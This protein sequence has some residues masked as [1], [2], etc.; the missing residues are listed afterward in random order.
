MLILRLLMR[1]FLFFSFVT[2]LLGLAS[3]G[4]RPNSSASSSEV[5]IIDVESALADLQDGLK[6]SY[7]G[8]RVR[9]VPLE[10]NDSC[11]V[12]AH[13]KA[14]V[15]D[16]YVLVT[17]RIGTEHFVHAF[18]RRTG[19]SVAKVGHRGE[20]P[21][22][23]TDFTPYYNAYNDLL[24]FERIP[25]QLQKYDW[26]GNYHGRAF[27]PVWPRR[28]ASYFFCDSLVIGYHEPSV[29]EPVGSRLLSVFDETGEVKDSVPRLSGFP[30]RKEEEIACIGNSRITD[31]GWLH[32]A[33]Y[34][35]GS[36]SCFLS[37]VH[38]LWK[39]GESIR[40]KDGLN[41]TIYTWEKGIGLYP[42]FV[43]HTGKEEEDSQGGSVRDSWVFGVF[44][45]SEK[46]FFQYVK[47]AFRVIHQ[48][49]AATL[50]F[51]EGKSASIEDFPYE[52]YNGMYDKQTGVTR[53]ALWGEGLED[54]LAGGPS[55]EVQ[56]TSTQEE[57]VGVL[58]AGEVVG[59]LEAH[60][61]AKDNPRLAPLLKVKEEDNPVVVIVSDK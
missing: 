46:I 31:W 60:P 26:Q 34:K 44:E 6:L 51:L 12:A 7:F 49:N 41:D 59:W 30:V 19:R 2:L 52:V 50:S 17:S 22:A 32:Y 3:C 37:N 23:Y 11:L 4:S 13:P 18:E 56:G 33:I 14:L 61:E 58:E 10:T 48:K 16:N 24:Y 9:Y 57:I 55:W 45:A 39:C 54:D 21:K 27:V 47:N 25:N 15:T 5:P 38:P 29:Y 20:D 42:S 36:I 28:P 8:S 53:M 35:D 43:F 40:L 1:I